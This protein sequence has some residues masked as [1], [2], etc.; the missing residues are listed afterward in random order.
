MFLRK[1]KDSMIEVK[2]IY[3]NLPKITKHT[4]TDFFVYR[5]VEVKGHAEHTG[6][7]NNTRVCAG[8][9]AITL[10]IIRLL[11]EQHKVEYHKGYFHVHV[12]RAINQEF[13]D[14]CD[15]ESVYALNTLVCQ[16]YEI[17]KNYPNAFKSFDLIEEKEN[18]ENETRKSSNSNTKRT[19]RKQHKLGLYSITESPN[20]KED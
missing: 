18:I 14:V 15:K 19:S 17:Y 12:D 16:L 7:T 4:K 13:K 3:T 9:S 20:L 8:I 6:Y 1:E 5:E 2:V 10:G 11:D